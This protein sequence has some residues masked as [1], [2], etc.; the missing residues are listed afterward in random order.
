MSSETKP[1]RYIVLDTNIFQHL[2]NDSLAIEIIKVLKEAKEK[3]YGLA[4]SQYSIL[5]LVDTANIDI[6]KRRLNVISGF[7]HFKV[8]QDILIVAGHLGCLYKDDGLT[9]KQQPERGD[10]II[11]ATAINHNCLIYTTNAKDFP[12]P[13]FKEIG[14]HWLTYKKNGADVAI[15]GYFMEPDILAIVRRYG[16]RINDK[17]VMQ[18]LPANE[19]TEA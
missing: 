7:K 2:G 6:E 13:Y 10:K 8:K 4:L 19:N 5:E 12:P 16:Q 14:R 11:G 3:N 1:L 18:L 15:V 17:S 9:E